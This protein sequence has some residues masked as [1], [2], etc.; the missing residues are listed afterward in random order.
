MTL[1]RTL[2]RRFIAQRLLCTSTIY[3][4][5]LEIYI[6]IYYMT[7]SKYKTMLLT[8]TMK[9]DPLLNASRGVDIAIKRSEIYFLNRNNQFINGHFVLNNVVER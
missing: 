2:E 9:C 7:S 1:K 6:Y 8:K 3:T 5:L 4:R